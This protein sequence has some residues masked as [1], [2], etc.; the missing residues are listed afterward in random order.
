MYDFAEELGVTTPVLIKWQQS[1]AADRPANFACPNRAVA[2]KP[3]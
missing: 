2:D 1:Y 3:R